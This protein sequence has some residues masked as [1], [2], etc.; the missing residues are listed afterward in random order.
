MEAWEV[1]EWEGREAQIR[2]LQE[3]QLKEF[4]DTIKAKHAQVLIPF[5]LSSCRGVCCLVHKR[6]PEKYVPGRNT[7]SV[8][9]AALYLQVLARRRR[10]ASQRG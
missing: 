1:A 8:T 5:S 7:Q 4:E 6:S 10:E 2:A 3:A 9:W